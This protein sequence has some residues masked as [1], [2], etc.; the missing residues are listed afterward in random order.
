MSAFLY[1][2]LNLHG[3]WQRRWNNEGNKYS[4]IVNVKYF[5]DNL[6]DAT[7]DYNLVTNT[8]TMCEWRGV[9]YLHCTA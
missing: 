5:Y 9:A 8:E 1:K 6:N 2:L 4:L 3:K 7:H